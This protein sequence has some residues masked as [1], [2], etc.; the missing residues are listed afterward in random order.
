MRGRGPRRVLRRLS[1]TLGL[2][3]SLGVLLPATPVTA[4]SELLPGQYVFADFCSGKIYT[5]PHTGGAITLQRDWTQNITSFGES[6]DGELY[7]VTITGRLHRV[8]AS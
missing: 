1:V 6:E 3:A 7:L 2:I 4:A 5:M 8:L